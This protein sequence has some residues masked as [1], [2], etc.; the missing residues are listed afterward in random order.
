MEHKV[1]TEMDEPFYI[2]G[3]RRQRARARKTFVG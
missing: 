2:D 1:D 3:D